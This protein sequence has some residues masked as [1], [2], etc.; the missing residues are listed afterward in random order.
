MTEHACND[1]N[2]AVE[3]R[4]TEIH[5]TEAQTICHRVAVWSWVNYLTS[6]SHSFLVCTKE[7]RQQFVLRNNTENVGGESVI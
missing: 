4:V 3:K 7:I 1:K 5:Q 2:N 6:L